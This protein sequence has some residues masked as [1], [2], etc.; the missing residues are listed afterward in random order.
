MDLLQL[1]QIKV[2]PAAALPLW[3]RSRVLAVLARAR[4]GLS[5]LRLS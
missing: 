5:V 1:W 3:L 2:G 4:K